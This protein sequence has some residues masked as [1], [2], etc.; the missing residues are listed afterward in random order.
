MNVAQ[1]TALRSSLKLSN[2]DGWETSVAQAFRT[3]FYT[4]NYFAAFSGDGGRTYC[5]IS[6]YKLA[7]SVGHKF[8]CD[9]QAHYIPA[10]NTMIWILLAE[11]GPLLMCLA[12][13]ETVLNSSAKSWTVYV[14]TGP[15]F[16][17]N[18]NALFDYPQISFGDNF[19]YLTF[20]IIDTPDA[21]ACRFHNGQLRERGTM[22][23]QYFVAANNQYTCPCQLSGNHGLFAAQNTTSQLRIYD[24]PETGNT[25][26]PHDVN[27]ATIPS[28]DWKTTTPAGNDWFNPNSKIST[29]VQ[30]A[31]R[32]RNELWVGWTGARRVAEQREATFPYPHIG[33][34]VIDVQKMTLLRQ[35]YLWNE[36]FAFAYPSLASNPGG[37]IAIAFACGGGRDYAQH[38]VG[39]LTR[40]EELVLVTNDQ[41]L[42]AGSHYV[43]A[44]MA[45]P[46]VDRFISAGWNSPKDA[47]VPDGRLNQPR[48]VL[49]ER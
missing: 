3:I 5:P 6:P 26:F 13:P 1:N 34:A 10:A 36:N 44:R 2:S 21:I 37:E 23:F 27:I 41:S 17:R 19:L 31:A 30:T 9:Q 7:T 46:D 20:N 38:G 43:T 24:W 29:V 12:S 14:L 11:D 25:I 22:H 33:L 47:T 35:R 18:Q 15:V 45:V 49:F 48:Y 39:F 8:C 16:S 42:E 32:S 40:Q 28:E 4:G